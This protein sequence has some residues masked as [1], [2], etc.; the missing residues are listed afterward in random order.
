MSCVL[1]GMRK[2]LVGKQGPADL[3]SRATVNT[4]PSASMANLAVTVLVDPY[5][6]QP[7]RQTVFPGY[8]LLRSDG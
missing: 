4:L 1:I 5:T 7:L 6:G 2:T 8:A 3:V